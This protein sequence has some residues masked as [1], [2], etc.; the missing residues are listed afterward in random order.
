[1]NNYPPRDLDAATAAAQAEPRQ[2]VQVTNGA[3]PVGRRVDV[4]D[5]LARLLEQ[6][7]RP[8]RVGLEAAKLIVQCFETVAADVERIAKERVDAALA[9][10][11]EVH[12]W[13][14]V[15]RESGGV[16]SDK[17]EDETGR[18]FQASKA[19]RQVRALLA[20]ELPT[21]QQQ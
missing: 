8:P 17:I 21:T 13:A 16:L 1:M 10:Q 18:L 12:T 3:A 5:G 2:D 19:F 7:P 9:L 20:D 6:P 14:T 15:L 11:Q 4:L